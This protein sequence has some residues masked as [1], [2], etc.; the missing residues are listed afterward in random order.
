ML[1][2]W[3]GLRSSVHPPRIGPSLPEWG[4]AVT[5]K[6]QGEGGAPGIVFP[7]ITDGLSGTADADFDGQVTISELAQF[8]DTS[9]GSQ[10]GMPLDRWARSQQLGAEHRG[11]RGIGSCGQ[12]FARPRC[13]VDA[14]PA[15]ACGGRTCKRRGHFR[16]RQRQHVRLEAGRVRGP[17]RA[18]GVRR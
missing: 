11:P 5:S 7:V 3:E 17:R 16:N 6:A 14:L 4:L 9:L 13:E 12:P 18:T 15:Q 2:R 8:L 1:T 10:A